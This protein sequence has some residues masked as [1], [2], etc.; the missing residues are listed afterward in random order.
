MTLHL[1]VRFG[2]G[3]TP[4][5]LPEFQRRWRA[6]LDGYF[7]T[8]LQLPR[9]GDQLHISL[10]LIP[11]SDNRQAIELSMS[12]APGQAD[13]LN[14][15]LRS[16][17]PALDPAQLRTRQRRNDMLGLHELAHFAGLPD[18]S[19]DPET[20]FRDT[21][22][23]S[24]GI[25]IMASL[26][27]ALGTGVP[28]RYLEIIEGTIDSGPVVR[29]HPLPPSVPVDRQ[30]VFDAVPAEVRAAEAPDPSTSP[31]EPSPHGPAQAPLRQLAD[32]PGLAG[33]SAIGLVLDE[34]ALGVDLVE[35]EQ[36]IAAARE[37]VRPGHP[38]NELHQGTRALRRAAYDRL[39]QDA[40]Q[41]LRSHREGRPAGRRAD[42]SI[43]ELPG[44]GHAVVYNELANRLGDG[45]G[46]RIEF[47]SRQRWTS[48]EYLLPDAPPT[49]DGLRAVADRTWGPG[50]AE[51]GAEQITYRL[52]GDD[53]GAVAR[54][55][56]HTV[57]DVRT[58]PPESAESAGRPWCVR[59]H[60]RR[61]RP[62]VPL[63][64]GGYVH[65]S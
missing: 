16:E 64:A 43:T 53:A 9:S 7:N 14:F 10:R 1:P 32:L 57:P 50:G 62:A 44:G 24:T 65:R 28:R 38:L 61:V 17:D 54:F 40:Q 6:A 31:D 58:V 12:P 46:L 18:T 15:R 48:R 52:T 2:E 39:L 55:A 20:V 42:F 11:V 4:E 36:L 26:A 59:G 27:P 51:S 8:G 49:M 47:D 60:R 37:A 19:F 5:M 63:R 23:K 45:P 25:G 3:F 33:R 22:G 35:T 34:D 21:R 41:A 13:Q 56:V 30:E 29:D